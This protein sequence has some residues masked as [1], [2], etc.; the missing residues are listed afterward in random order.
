MIRPEDRVVV[1]STAHGLKFADQ[2]TA[3]H[4]GALPGVHSTHANRPVELPPDLTRI[5]A[6]IA[7]HADRARLAADR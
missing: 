2:K 6:A 7:E 1:I 5:T 4:T 3:Y